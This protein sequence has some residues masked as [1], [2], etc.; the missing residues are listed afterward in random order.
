[1]RACAHHGEHDLGF[2]RPVSGP[3]VK[4]GLLHRLIVRALCVAGGDVGRGPRHCDRREHLPR[5]VADRGRGGG[6]GS[7]RMAEIPEIVFSTTPEP[8]LT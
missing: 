7:A 2:R 4:V 1:M 3:S 8:P 6:P 5:V